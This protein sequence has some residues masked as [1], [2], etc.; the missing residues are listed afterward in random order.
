[1][2]VKSGQIAITVVSIL[3]GI[4]LAIQFKTV[5]NTV[6]EGVLPVQRA[7]Q[8]AVDLKKAQEERD[9]AIKALNEAENKIKQY[10]KG[11]ADNNIYVENLI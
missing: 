6:G 11:E 10:E 8:L 9:A 1:M 5:N 2:K 7:Q 4:I 3:L